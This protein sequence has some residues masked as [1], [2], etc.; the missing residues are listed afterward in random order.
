MKLFNITEETKLKVMAALSLVALSI[1]LMAMAQAGTD[2]T[3]DTWVDQVEDW[4]EGSLGRGISLAM[5]AVGVIGAIRQ[6][7]L[8]PIAMG[9]GAALGLNYAPAV[10]GGMF[11]GVIL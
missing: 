7:T 1:V 9:V 4:L 2:T 8:F 6:Q 10:I 5:V 3:F 11:T